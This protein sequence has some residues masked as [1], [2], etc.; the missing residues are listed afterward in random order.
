MADARSRIQA[1]SP[2]RRALM[3]ALV[4]GRRPDRAPTTP[5]QERY[6]RLNQADPA[7]PRYL[8]PWALSLCG[9]LDTDGLGRAVRSVLDRHDLLTSTFRRQDGELWQLRG[10]APARG[11]RP[12]EVPDGPDG[13]Q[14]EI[15]RINRRGRDLARQPPVDTTL[16]RLGPDRHVLVVDIHAIANDAWS[17]RLFLDDLA[18]HY[19]GSAP[20]SRP[21]PFAEHAARQRRWLAGAEAERQTR[22]WVRALAG[23][24]PRLLPAAD[25]FRSVTR[26]TELPAGVTAAVRDLGRRAG[27]TPFM[28]LYALVA[29]VLGSLTGRTDIAVASSVSGRDTPDTHHVVGCFVNRVVLRADLS[30]A[31][32]ELELVRRGR[33]GVRQA[34]ANARLPFEHVV[35]RVL[36]D[37][38]DRPAPLTDV[39]FVYDDQDGRAATGTAPRFAG[40][41]TSF[42]EPE[43]R[44]T[45]FALLLTA[46]PVPSGRLVLEAHCPSGRHHVRTA[47]ELLRRCAARLTRLHG[48]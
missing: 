5:A 47:D 28:T 38:Y 4:A 21:L 24:P 12:V 45:R 33:E 9:P 18:A 15:E 26:R 42:V 17:M 32:G 37:E 36:P 11:P 27:A 30:G 3:D 40:L 14:R 2:D 7:D 31:P 1:L 20:L 29:D 19:N 25:G 6:W 44:T 41:E 43:Y 48:D 10:T 46:R 16:L 13:V 22:H 35:R 34:L 39:M 23:L 8:W